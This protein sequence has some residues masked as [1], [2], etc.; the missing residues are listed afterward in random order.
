[1]CQIISSPYVSGELK[2]ILLV[3]GSLNVDTRSH[4]D[5]SDDLLAN[6]VPDF[7]LEVVGVLVLLD[8]YVDG[9]TEAQC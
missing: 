7:N 6:E 3:G 5:P 8:V 2:L 9:E 1:M 4:R